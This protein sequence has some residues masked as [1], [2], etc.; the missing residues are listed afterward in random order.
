VRGTCFVV[1]ELAAAHP[2]LVRDVAAAGHEVAL[3]GWHHVPLTDLD[4][5]TFSAG[6]RRGKTLLED[7]TGRPVVG[8]RAPSFSLVPASSWAVEEL[9]AL[10]FAYSSSALPARSPLFG[11]PGLPRRPF[12]W[13]SGLL[14]L[15]VP[16]T[17]IAGITNA[18]LGGAY[19]RVLPPSV[20]RAGLRRAGDDELL[21]TYCHPYDFDPDE[22]FAT[23]PGLSRRASRILW[24]NRSRM[25][26]RVTRLLDGRAADPLA[27]RA[28]ALV[29]VPQR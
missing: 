7:L 5:A 18:Y 4:A 19:L 3:H 17:T 9:A 20:V 28:A 29:D 11:W 23:R 27:E 8:Y 26:G 13:E 1:G 15:P 14:E 21:W 6:T 24:I 2:D 22:P 16:V 25:L 10:G 12:R